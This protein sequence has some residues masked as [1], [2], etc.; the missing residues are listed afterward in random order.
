MNIPKK[1]SSRISKELSKFQKILKHAAAKDINEADTVT[2]VADILARIFGFDKYSNI[3]KEHSIRGTFCDLAIEIKGNVK[4][5]IEV[6]AIGIGL[7]E[8]HLRQA[9]N[10][11]ANKGVPWV[12][13]TNG[14]LWEIYKIK[15][16]RPVG[17]HHLCTLNLLDLNP[18]K[19]EDQNKLFILCKEGLTKDALDE[20]HEYVMC[21]NKFTVGAIIRSDEFVD[22]IRRELR[23]FSPN[24]KVDKDNVYT[25]L[26]NE[27]L[28]REILEGEDAKKA[29]KKVKKVSARPLRKRRKK[30]SKKAS[31]DK[32]DES[33]K[34]GNELEMPSEVT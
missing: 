8:S 10:Y 18:R 30:R 27:V 23:R 28:K 24:I 26:L 19:K 22:K 34:L 6:K 17:F 5:L 33:P 29:L 25:I 15:F 14:L 3:T 12:I 13:L 16:E 31:I 1:V 20:F 4:Y 11:G 32:L 7:K 2:I 9:V 21:V